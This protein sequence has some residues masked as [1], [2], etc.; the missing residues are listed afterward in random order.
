MA[1]FAD[2]VIVVTGASEGI[3]RALCL[4]L[5]DQKARLVLAARNE[6][7]LEVLK[8][9]VESKGGQAVVVPTDVTDEGACR[10]LVERAV[11]QWGGLD[12]LVNNAGVTM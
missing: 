8:K 10:R 5:A 4:A 6:S 1:A 11:A 3:G 7:R 9:E 12:A 2:R